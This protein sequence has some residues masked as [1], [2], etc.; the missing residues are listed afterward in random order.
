MSTEHITDT[1]QGAALFT[2]LY[3]R[4]GIFTQWSKAARVTGR[5]DTLR[6]PHVWLKPIETALIVVQ[7]RKAIMY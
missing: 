1:H 3:E 7:G 4:S 5:S 6:C 2:D